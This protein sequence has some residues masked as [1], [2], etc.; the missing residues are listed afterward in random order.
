MGKNVPN[1]QPGMFL[2]QSRTQTTRSR[3]QTRW[4]PFFCDFIGC[5]RNKTWLTHANS[6]NLR[7]FT[8]FTPKNH[9]SLAKYR[10][11]MILW[12]Y[13]VSVPPLVAKLTTQKSQILLIYP[14]GCGTGILSAVPPVVWVAALVSGRQRAHWRL[15]TEHLPS[16]RSLRSDKSLVEES[17]PH[18]SQIVI[19]WL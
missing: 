10:Y 7:H 1:H 12:Y 16:V 15:P 18:H 3:D 2:S 4:G 9:G 6:T 13:L 11:C 8:D 14:L 19:W 17:E 5:A